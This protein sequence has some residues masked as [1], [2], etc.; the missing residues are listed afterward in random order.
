MRQSTIAFFTAIALLAASDADATT[1]LAIW[2]RGEIVIA[3]DSL[4]SLELPTG[5]RIATQACKIRNFGDLVFG[6]AGKFLHPVWTPGLLAAY[7]RGSQ[8]PIRSRAARFADEMEARLR[9]VPHNDREKLALNITY[10]IGFFEESQPVLLSQMAKLVNGEVVVNPVEEIPEGLIVMP[11][12]SSL[13]DQDQ[14]SIVAFQDQP[15]LSTLRLPGLYG[16]FDLFIRR[17]AWLTPA[18]VGLPVDII[19][20][21][22]DGA[23][24]IHAKDECR[25]REPVE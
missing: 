1:V 6:A 23:T 20:L 14:G 19:R 12:E 24:W 2:Q 8:E 13:L 10:V 16:F 11:G 25:E 22:A 7:L 17:Q 9:R 18:T 3:A 21:T 15:D 4:R 5:E